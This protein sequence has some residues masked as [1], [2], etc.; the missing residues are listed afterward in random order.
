MRIALLNTMTPYV[1]G[2][3]EILV[4]DLDMQLKLHGHCSE[5]F[6]LPFP[7]SYEGPLMRNIAVA[8]ML[9]FDDYDRVIAF[10]FPAYCVRH[11]AKVIWMFHQFRQVYDLWNTEYGLA[12]NSKTETIKEIIKT[13]DNTDIPLARHVYVNAKEVANRLWHYNN[14]HSD[15][16]PPPLKNAEDYYNGNTGDYIYY[17]SRITFLK[18]QHLAIEAMRYTKSGVKLLI[19]GKC[20]EP[21]YTQMLKDLINSYNLENRVTIEYGWISDEKKI[22]KIADCLGIM[23]IP[24]KEDSCGFVSMEGFYAGKPVVTCADSGGTS[25]LVEDG[26]TGYICEPNPEAIACVLDKLFEDKK[27]AEQMGV[28]AREE[29]LRRNITWSET[30]RRLLL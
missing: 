24:Y 21:E 13:T 4:D 19:S 22:S 6:R 27:L 25:E 30:I 7:N 23:Y 3:A 20:D 11:Q 18:R 10:K 16:L 8:R 17:P 12:S 28:A 26:R 1:R 2:G 9:R 29:I 15:I 5:I 14:I